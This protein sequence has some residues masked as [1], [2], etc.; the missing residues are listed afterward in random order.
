MTL[1]RTDTSRARTLR[2]RKIT[3][4]DGKVRYDSKDP[5]DIAAELRA[6][7]SLG[8]RE[9]KLKAAEAKIGR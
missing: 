8:K 4:P 9:A 1:E 5:K 3:M 2:S 7:S 6:K